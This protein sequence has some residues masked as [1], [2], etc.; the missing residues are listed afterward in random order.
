MANTALEMVRGESAVFDLAITEADGS[1]PTGTL[2]GVITFI[3]KRH[4][5]DEDA[6]LTLDNDLLGGVTV[7]D[8]ETWEAEVALDPEDTEG[9]PDWDVQL[10]WSCWYE[11]PTSERYPVDDGTLLVRAVA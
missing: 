10:F 4:L 11:T 6:F 5:E 8:A 3:V 2:D 7:E 1:E 9:L